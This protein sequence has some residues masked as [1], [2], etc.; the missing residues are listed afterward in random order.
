MHKTFKANAK[1]HE[2]GSHYAWKI[3]FGCTLLI[4][5]CMGLVSSGFSVYFPFIKQSYHFSNTQISTLTT[6]RYVATLLAQIYINDYYRRVEMRRGMGIAAGLAT[7]SFVLFGLSSNYPAYMLAAFIGGLS[8]GLGTMIPVSILIRR[9]FVQNQG[10]ALGISA[11]GSGAATIIAAPFITWMI[12]RMS[13]SIAFL[14]EAIMSLVLAAVIYAVV[15]NTP[16]DKGVT[17]LGEHRCNTDYQK[18]HHTYN[19]LTDT[20]ALLLKAV[21]LVGGA[22]ANPAFTHLSLLYASEGYTSSQAAM[23]V[24]GVGVILTLSKIAFGRFSDW[25][26]GFR[27]SVLFGVILAIGLVSGCFAHL[28]NPVINGCAVVLMGIGFPIAT[29]GPS[30]WTHDLAPTD[31]YAKRLREFMLFFTIGALVFSPIPGVIADFF[32]YYRLVYCLFLLLL[33]VML[34]LLSNVYRRVLQKKA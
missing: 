12:Q 5:V 27:A 32:G 24:S 1:R 11:A 13:L 28:M 16:Q 4:F 33:L 8:Y 7:I 34:I 21:C 29:I 2:H 30:I 20:D 31:E 26:G 15:R 25:I 14:L 18:L 19:K 3:C 23:I 9:W 22:L 6:I 10:V 17:A